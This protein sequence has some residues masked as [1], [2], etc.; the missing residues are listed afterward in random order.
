MVLPD[1]VRVLYFC[2]GGQQRQARG[3]RPP[4]LE[5][6]YLHLLHGLGHSAGE[7][8]CSVKVLGS[9]IAPVHVKHARP[10]SSLMSLEY[11]PLS[12]Q[13]IFRRMFSGKG[14]GVAI[15]GMP[16]LSHSS[17]PAAESTERTAVF[18]GDAQRETTQD[19][20][21]RAGYGPFPR[22]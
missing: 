3:V 8:V 6:L 15:Q 4:A 11:G 1:C 2:E 17:S 9:E 20:A 21:K 5:R 10:P 18:G 12:V 13:A 19:E 14:G 22:R 16:T 7:S